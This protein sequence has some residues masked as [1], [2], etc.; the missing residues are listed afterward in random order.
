MPKPE[1]RRALKAELSRDELA[2]E[3]TAKPKPRGRRAEQ[4]DA[5]TG[6]NRTAQH[7]NRDNNHGSNNVAALL[8]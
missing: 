4:V 8:L 5:E 1:T 7:G 3:Q 6:E 2:D